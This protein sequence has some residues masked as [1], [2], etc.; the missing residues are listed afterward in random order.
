MMEIYFYANFSVRGISDDR[1]RV[2][3]LPCTRNCLP[4]RILGKHIWS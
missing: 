4:V 1:Y 2:V 3:E